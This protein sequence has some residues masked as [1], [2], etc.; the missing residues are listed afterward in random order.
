MSGAHNFVEN[1]SDECS[2]QFNIMFDQKILKW[3]D[4]S[5]FS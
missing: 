3:D 4:W 1:H 2:F 5:N